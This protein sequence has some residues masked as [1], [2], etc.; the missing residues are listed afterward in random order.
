MASIVIQKFGGRLL[1]TPERVKRAAAFIIQTREAGWNPVVVV[2]APGKTTDQFLSLIRQITDSPTERE[3]D[4]L[5]SVGE[6]AA[7]S[8]LAIAIN[9]DGR[10]QAVSFTGSQVGIITDNRHT[11]ARILE[12]KGYRLR[13]AIAEGR[14]P[15]VAGFQGVSLDREITTLGRGGSDLTAM[16]LAVA[17]K[18]DRC[19]LIKEFGGVFTADP[20]AVPEAVRHE[21]VDYVTLEAMTGA[22]A[23]IVQPQAAAMARE[24]SVSV[25]V[26]GLSNSPGTLVS[27]RSLAA[28]PAAGVVL[29]KGLQVSTPAALKD[30]IF[31]PRNRLRYLASTAQGIIAA[32]KEDGQADGTKA[33][34]LVNVVGW[35]GTLDETVSGAVVDFILR[36]ELKP[37]ATSVAQGGLSILLDSH[38]G[39]S[40][41]RE[42]HSLLLREGLLSC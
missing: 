6:R 31:S 41:T 25:V 19:E 27:D 42:L 38:S 16:A 14:I 32:W 36:S 2:S 9:A 17:L 7:M 4:M 40:L 22:G 15:I 26:R 37:W 20:V 13:E 34:A 23:R 30:L 12:V 21:G 5:L 35:G 10:Y 1:E 33:A 28:G 18:A 29:E 3:T 11:Q 24:H 39:E 8:L